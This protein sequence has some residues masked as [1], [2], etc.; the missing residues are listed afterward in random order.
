MEK[1]QRLHFRSS[2]A[3]RIVTTTPAASAP[4]V[5][6]L[7]ETPDSV[8]TWTVELR[9]L[10]AEGDGVGAAE[11]LWWWLANILEADAEPSWT[12]RELIAR[13]GRRDLAPAVR[14]LD[15]MLY[16]PWSPD[17]GE[18]EGLWR[19]LAE[20]SRPATTGGTA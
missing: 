14:R 5:E 10:L 3:R 4:E 6:P 20:R 16:G 1:I 12:S 18:V 7:V 2:S 17:A 13:V 15:W 8:E 9:R 11:A 19:D